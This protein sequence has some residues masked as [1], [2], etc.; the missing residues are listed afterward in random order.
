[1]NHTNEKQSSNT[2][3]EIFV[4]KL[5]QLINHES[6]D[7]ACGVPDFILAEHL[8]RAL[9][10]F[11]LSHEENLKYHGIPSGSLTSLDDTRP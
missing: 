10:S 8:G 1:M 11:K 3:Y 5:K 9:R 6:I 4:K 2:R 7:A